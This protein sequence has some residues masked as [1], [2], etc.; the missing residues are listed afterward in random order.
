[1]PEH[2][3]P[4]ARPLASADLAE[5][6][7]LLARAAAADG[8]APLSDDLLSAAEADSAVRIGLADSDGRLAGLAIAAAQGERTGAEA[9][10]DP[11]LRGRG[12]G[13]L[14]LD[15][16]EGALAESGRQGWYWSHGDHPAAAHLAAEASR[17]RARQLLQLTT[18]RFADGLEIPAVE[19]PDGVALRSVEPADADSWAAVNNAAFA[20][21]PEQGGQDPAEYRAR[22]AEPAFDRESVIIAESDGTV[23]G[24]HETKVHDDHPSGLRMGEVYVIGVDPSAGVRGVGR[25]LLAEGMRR[26]RDAGAEA[27]ELYVEGDNASALRLYRGF[28]F[29]RAVVHACYAPA[30]WTAPEDTEAARPHAGEEGERR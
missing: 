25:A 20:W 16:L 23:I 15:A 27:V 4:E 2:P 28:G 7:P 24:F 5:A 1:M 19:A 29:D 6:R 3:L 18:A 10:V 17:P 12:W 9:V 14:L 21:H 30:G 22:L 8:T 11:E 26:L 13:R